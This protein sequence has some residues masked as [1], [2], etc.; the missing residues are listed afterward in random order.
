M[1]YFCL[2]KSGVTPNDID[3]YI[4]FLTE[5]SFYLFNKGSYKLPSDNFLDFMKKYKAKFNLHLHESTILKKLK[6][7]KLISRDSFGNYYFCYNYIYYFFIAKY[8]AENINENKDRIDTI[9]KNLHKNQNAYI[10]IFITHHSKDSFLLEELNNNAKCIFENYQQAS[11]NN[12]EVRFLDEQAYKYIIKP[13]LPKNITP[14]NERERILIAEGEIEE[15]AKKENEEEDE[16]LFIIELRKGNRFVEVMGHIIKNRSGSLNKKSLECIFNNAMAIHL[17]ALSLFFDMIKKENHQK[18]LISFISKRLLKIIKNNEITEEK[19]N[20]TA[21]KIFWNLSF[22]TI[23]G[24]INKITRALG[25]KSLLD[26]INNVCD[27]KDSPITFMIKH[28]VCM[29]YNKSLYLDDIS[30]QIRK[31]NFSETVKRLIELQVIEYCSMHKI[32]YKDRQR[33]LEKFE[34]KEAVLKKIEHD[35]NHM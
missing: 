21:R 4:N 5:I 33:I 13:A 14:E 1:I 6:E 25:S 22:F 29:W 19:L 34:I 30:D 31:G 11:L 15:N 35:F 12:D 18:E 8:L 28:C 20:Y 16:N 27:N 23:Y 2:R 9:I 10:M 7:A 3:T 26:V 24:V 17:R 32:S